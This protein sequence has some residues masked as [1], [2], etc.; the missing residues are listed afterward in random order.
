LTLDLYLVDAT[1]STLFDRH[2]NDVAA[3]V[4]DRWPV[5]VLGIG[6]QVKRLS[7]LSG[8]DSAQCRPADARGVALDELRHDGVASHPIALLAPRINRSA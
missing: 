3:S 5:R 6:I 7:L 1:W 2:Y 8:G 4:I